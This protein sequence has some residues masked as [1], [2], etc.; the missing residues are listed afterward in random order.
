[1]IDVYIKMSQNQNFKIVAASF[2][3]IRNVTKNY[4]LNLL[5]S[6]KI[7]QILGTLIPKLEQHDADKFVK[8]QVIR[9]LGP[10]FA[11]ILPNLPAK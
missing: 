4:H 1:M 11:Y 10:I 6:G 8:I 7:N 9:C 2:D 3:G 5:K